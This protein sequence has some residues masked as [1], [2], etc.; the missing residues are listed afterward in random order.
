M[1]SSNTQN[2]SQLISSPTLCSLKQT[3]LPIQFMG[4]SLYYLSFPCDLSLHGAAMEVTLQGHTDRNG[5][6]RIWIYISL[7][8][9]QCFQNY[10]INQKL[11]EIQALLFIKNDW[12]LIKGISL[13]HFNLPYSHPPLPKSIVSWKSELAKL[14]NLPSLNFPYLYNGGWKHLTCRL[15]TDFC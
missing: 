1:L 10:H 2:L 7:I 9:N 6:L 14:F 5:R 3:P 15:L 4:Y 12:I 13:W 8:Q 11:T